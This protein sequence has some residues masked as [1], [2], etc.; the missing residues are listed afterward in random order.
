MFPKRRRLGFSDT[1][2]LKFVK[3]LSCTCNFKVKFSITIDVVPNISCY[4][5]YYS[6]LTI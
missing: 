6:L 2:L 5:S 1:N 3:C 4:L